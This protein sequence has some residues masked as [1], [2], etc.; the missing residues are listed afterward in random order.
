[1]AIVNI[2]LPNLA[3]DVALIESTIATIEAAVP[4]N[5]L[6]Y[7]KPRFIFKGSEDC[8]T[9]YLDDVTDYQEVRPV[10]VEN[11][12]LNVTYSYKTACGEI[13]DCSS[14]SMTVNGRLIFGNTYGDG[15]YCV[16][17]QI[18]YVV[19]SV[20]YTDTVKYCLVQDC[21]QNKVIDLR[22]EISDCMASLSCKINEYKCIGRNYFKLTSKYLQMSNLLW[23]MDNTNSSCDDYSSFACLFKKI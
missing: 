9:F 17:I 2:S 14:N 16:S 18:T 23:V 15:E 21:C 4:N 22:K 19:E 13:I 5:L 6:S 20:T 3:T 10:T 11:V 12:T 8:S 1:M 7:I